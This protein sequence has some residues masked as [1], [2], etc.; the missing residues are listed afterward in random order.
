M[1]GA[2]SLLPML[3]APCRE[4]LGWDAERWTEEVAD[5]LENWVARHA[6]PAEN[7]RP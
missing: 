5:H 6:P 2:E 3:E 4:D 7:R 1:R